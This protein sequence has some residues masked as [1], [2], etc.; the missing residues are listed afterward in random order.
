[1]RLF[2]LG[3]GEWG[4][5]CSLPSLVLVTV[6][7]D[8]LREPISRRKGNV[9]LAEELVLAFVVFRDAGCKCEMLCETPRFV[10]SGACAKGL[11]EHIGY[12]KA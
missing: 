12:E 7:G 4:G 3:G 5:G 6:I 1:M 8:R 2:G 11:P 9:T 10:L